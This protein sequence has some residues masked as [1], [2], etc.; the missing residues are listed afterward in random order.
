MQENQIRDICTFMLSKAVEQ[1]KIIE[2]EDPRFQEGFLK[3]CQFSADIAEEFRR[4]EKEMII[5]S[6]VN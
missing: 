5:K 3:G 6:K 4:R 2:H 1:V